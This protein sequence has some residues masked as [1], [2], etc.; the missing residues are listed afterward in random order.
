MP[1]GDS[2]QGKTDMSVSREEMTTGLVMDVVTWRCRQDVER[3]VFGKQV[4]MSD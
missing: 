3:E 2:T 1:K 4:G